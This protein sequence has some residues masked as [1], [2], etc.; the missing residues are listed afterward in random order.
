MRRVSIAFL[1][2]TLFVLACT[3]KGDTDTNVDDSSPTN[4]GGPID[5]DLDGS[6]A[7]SDCD[8]HDPNRA[9]TLAEECDGIDNDCDDAVDEDV[10]STYYA[11]ADGDGY[12][13]RTS[14]TEA[15]EPSA[16]WS[17][18][19]DD[20][21]DADS[22]INPDATELCDGIDNNCNEQTDEGTADSLWYYD[23][24]GDG[25]GDPDNYI[26]SCDPPEGYVDN[27]WDCDDLDVLEPVH[28]AE[29]GHMDTGFW[30]TADTGAWGSEAAPYGSIQDGILAA[31]ACVLV[32]GGEYWEDVNFWGKDVAVTGVDGAENTFI[33]GTG[34]A[35]VVTFAQG[36]SSNASL[37]GF[38]ISGGGGEWAE[39]VQTMDCSSAYTCTEYWIT[40]RG[41]GV[42]ISGAN[43]TLSNLVLSANYLPAYSMSRADASTVTYISSMGGGI[44]VENATPPAFDNVQIVDNSAD[45]GG[46]AYVNNDATT[47][48]RW[49]WVARNAA[50]AGG[51]YY[52]S[53][54]T[55]IENSVLAMNTSDGFNG[56]PGG[57]A[58]D[59]SSSTG[60]LSMINVSLYANE[61]I[62]SIYATS[63]SSIAIS[64]SIV[65]ENAGGS[66][67]DGE[68]TASLSITYSDVYGCSADLYGNWTDMTGTN[69]NLA[70]DPLFVD[71]A[72]GNFQLMSR[73]SSIDAGDP[74][75]AYND[76][77]GTRNDQGAYGGP[78]GAW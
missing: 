5:E 34:S 22:G 12:G 78:N 10:M 70:A 45:I 9:P 18:N 4:T 17:E 66:C 61:G 23:N 52:S 59:V 58:A 11:D 60:F 2:P 21:N 8:D 68:T 65:F 77:D 16:G 76:T 35:P 54:A 13:D 19:A 73:S 7:D 50:S 64:N 69:G 39:D 43:P 29:G 55:S 57:A 62:A 14:S 56:N 46:G 27:N 63:E 6:D 37:S 33:Y 48:W 31:S 15:C 38:T 26:E 72:G 36:E 32:H 67:L 30:D 44:Y 75:A 51:G 47:E 3:D 42:Y 25:Y 41:G 71:A 40:Y 53:G 74:D 49:A 20:C 1:M 24:D 28:V